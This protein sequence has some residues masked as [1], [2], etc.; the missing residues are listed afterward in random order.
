M[1]EG[2]GSS[3][4]VPS[5]GVKPQLGEAEERMERED[6]LR[7]SEGPGSKLKDLV[8]SQNGSGD[9]HTEPSQQ[10]ALRMPTERERQY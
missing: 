4:S 2:L 1:C 8:S 7:C 10:P 5:T 9:V 6:E 3:P